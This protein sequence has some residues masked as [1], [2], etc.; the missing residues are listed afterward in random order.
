MRRKRVPRLR[1]FDYTGGHR[2]FLT[3]CTQRRLRVFITSKAVDL[4]LVQ[5]LRSAR[6]ERIAV[7]AYCF[8]PDHLHLLVEGTDP[9]SELTEFVRIF[10]QRS[11]F[12]WKS[13]FG[14]ELWQRSYFEH[15]LRS[16]ESSIDAARYVLANPLRAGMVSSVEDYPFLGS[17]TM[18]VRELL[19]SVS[20]DGGEGST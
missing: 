17:L 9:A 8:M 15:V 3:L 1:G 12:H 6:D 13:A 11:S 5:L 20:K 7:F 2:Y 19:H 18:S 16:H 14:S 4:V 10:K